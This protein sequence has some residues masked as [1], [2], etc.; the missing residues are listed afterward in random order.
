[1]NFP[2]CFR[3]TKNS[4]SIQEKGVGKKTPYEKDASCSRDRQNETK[5]RGLKGRGWKREII[6]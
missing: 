6:R 2:K 4:Q 1:M 3:T 5:T